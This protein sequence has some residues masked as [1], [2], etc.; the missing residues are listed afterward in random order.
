MIYLWASLLC[1]VNAACVSVTLLMLPG[2]W[3]MLATTMLVAWWLRGAG[4]FSPWTLVAIVVLALVAELV[5]FFSSAVGV[6]KAGGTRWGGTGSLLG[7]VV[8][9]ICGTLLIP[10]PL[11][12]S[13]IGVCVGA[14]GGAL[15]GELATG[16]SGSDS[17]KSA[18][19]AGAGRL[20]GTA[21]KFIIGVVIWS[22]IA[23]AA[24]WP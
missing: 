10:I 17:A 18:V 19:G 15:V 1:V 7:A 20:V 22:I 24:F 8:G 9:A 5:E 14:G 2:N 12:G 4:M 16:R 13:L 11:L 21:V 3:M 23:I 6:S